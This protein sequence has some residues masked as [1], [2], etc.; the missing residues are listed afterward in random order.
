MNRPS[1]LAALLL[2][3]PF[4]FG[5]FGCSKDPKESRSTAAVQEDGVHITFKFLGVEEA[6]F[7]GKTVRTG[8]TLTIPVE[9]T[10]IGVNRPPL[11]G[12]FD[13]PQSVYFNVPAERLLKL[14]CKGTRGKVIVTEAKEDKKRSTRKAEKL[15]EQDCGTDWGV[16]EGQLTTHNG[17]TVRLNG[18]GLTN[19]TYRVDRREAWFKEKTGAKVRAEQRNL[20]PVSLPLEVHASDGDV[21]KANFEVSS[22]AHFLSGLVKGLPQSAEG[23]PPAGD[24][25][26]LRNKREWTFSKSDGTFGELARFA[27]VESESSPRFVQSCRYEGNNQSK[28]YAKDWVV[29]ARDRSGKEIGR[30]TFKSRWRGCSSSTV[31]SGT[32]GRSK[33]YSLPRAEDVF[34]WVFSL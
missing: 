2:G 24:L 7:M 22:N 9:Q 8:D 5:S 13:H 1:V 14:T 6:T 28:V 12:D 23:M 10:H 16:I 4:A 21:W 11:E 26:V 27:E 31:A 20:T 29:V 17:A 25:A 15:F 33:S 32:G 30:K 18:E 3:L 19:D 34:K